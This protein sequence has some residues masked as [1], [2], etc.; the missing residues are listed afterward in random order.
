MKKP[1][2]PIEELE[3]VDEEVKEKIKNI[4]PLE[5]Y[6]VSFGGGDGDSGREHPNDIIAEIDCEKISSINQESVHIIDCHFFLH[7]GDGNFGHNPDL[8][9]GE[10]GF[11]F[12]GDTTDKLDEI[13][14]DY[15]EPTM[16]NLKQIL[17]IAE[18]IM[19]YDIIV[20][21]PTYHL[22]YLIELEESRKHHTSSLEY[23]SLHLKAIDNE[24]EK[25]KAIIQTE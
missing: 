7:I 2:R 25:Y 19:N 13:C 23:H 5:Y 22:K 12:I 4:N 9:V 24:I 17:S 16:A 10:N 18:Y 8:M 20:R 11:Y 3:V 21:Y 14:R 1:I 6:I 15:K